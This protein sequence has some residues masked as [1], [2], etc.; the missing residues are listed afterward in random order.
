MKKILS[1][2]TIATLVLFWSCSNE[3]YAEL[4]INPDRPSVAPSDFLF[5]AATK[6]L[7]DQMTSIS[8]NLNHFRFFAQYAAQRNFAAESNYELVE[9]NVP[10]NHWSELYRDVLFDLKDARST[11]AN[12][13]LEPAVASNRIALI[14]ILNIYAWQQLVD[15]FGDIPYTE[16]LNGAAGFSPAYDDAQT[17]YDDL[18]TRIDAALNLLNTSASG[19]ES[20]LLY[21]GDISKW[22]KFGNSLKLRLAIRVLEV[23]TL[24][25]KAQSA[26]NEAIT[27]G[28]FTS[29]ADNATMTYEPAQPNTNPVFVTVDPSI[30]G[31]P[32]DFF[33]ANTI[34][35]YMNGLDDPR[36]PF[37]FDDNITDASGVVYIGGTYGTTNDIAL[38]TLLGPKLI[39][40]TFRGVLMSY[41]E[42]SFMLTQATELGVNTGATAATH[43]ANGIT[44]SMLDWGVAQ[45]DID[46]YQARTDVNYATASGTWQEKLGLQYWLAM[47]NRGFEGWTAWRQLDAPMLNV[48]ADSGSPVP[49]RYTYPAE[50][51]TLNGTNYTAASTAIGGDSQQTKIFWDVN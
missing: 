44:A 26:I 45:A 47:F 37:Y 40:P 12:E 43:Y 3:E 1:I 18:F 31:R 22:A 16:A 23:P 21:N 46:T 29:N 25:A 30:S 17:I 38:T 9:R 28:V 50:E 42:V 41:A 49:V 35:D 5:A 8:V 13:V 14:E 6:S 34:V 32:P 4:N 20:D 19:F 39:E 27:A 48:A 15:T 51:Q 10:L 11:I 36:R 2:F 33:P 24:S 7:V